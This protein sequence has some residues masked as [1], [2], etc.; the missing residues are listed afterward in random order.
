MKTF[1]LDEL[2]K[3]RATYRST[4]DETI[5]RINALDRPQEYKDKRISSIERAAAE[6]AKSIAEF[7]RVIAKLEK[8]PLAPDSHGGWLDKQALWN[9]ALLF[10]HHDPTDYEI[11]VHQYGSG[12][13]KIS[14]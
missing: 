11:E 2:K 8:A 9:G 14:L 12:I 13:V 4:K 1:N 10:V 3:E 7:D 6:N 5:A